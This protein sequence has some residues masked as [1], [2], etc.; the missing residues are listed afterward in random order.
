MPTFVIVFGITFYA[1]LTA[2]T[3][4]LF[5]HFRY[6]KVI[7]VLRT[8]FLK[9]NLFYRQDISVQ[10]NTSRNNNTVS[11][12]RQLANSLFTTAV[13]FYF[14]IYINLKE[15]INVTDNMVFNNSI[16]IVGH[17]YEILHL[18]DNPFIGLNLTNNNS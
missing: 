5:M 9:I 6:C 16:A 2:F 18:L 4:N 7:Y 17:H 15:T 8:S 1:A 3:E 14:G 11:F 12:L 13:I 10:L